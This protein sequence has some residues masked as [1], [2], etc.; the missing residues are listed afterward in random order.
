[1]SEAANSTVQ[2]TAKECEIRWLGERHPQF[3]H[4]QWSQ[5]EIAKVRELVDGAREGEVD[6]VEI[7]EKLG[8]CLSLNLTVIA[9]VGLLTPFDQTGRTPVDCM[10]HAIP[11]RTHTWTPEADQRLLEAVDMYG[12]DSWSLGTS[13]PSIHVHSLLLTNVPPQWH[14]GSRRTPR[15]RSAKAAT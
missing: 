12:T 2:R 3:N 15:L 14:E 13:A 7:A 1:M 5:S 6:W 9:T 11:R 4:A 8:V 10:R